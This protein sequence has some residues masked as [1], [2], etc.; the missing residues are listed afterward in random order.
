MPKFVQIPQALRLELDRF[1]SEADQIVRSFVGGLETVPP[2][3][4]VY[5]YS[6]ASGL[7]GI[8]ESGQLWLSD[9]F[10]LNDPSE[11]KHGISYV[12]EML[13]ERAAYGTAEAKGFAEHFEHFF[14]TGLE[15]TAHYFVLSLGSNGDHLAQWRWIRRQLPWVRSGLRG[16]SSRRRFHTSRRPSHSQQQHAPR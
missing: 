6:D 12:T 2:P 16:Q 1:D 8:L 5:H 7:R 14:L 3:A 9:I 10:S 15:K 11:L 4:M 13:K